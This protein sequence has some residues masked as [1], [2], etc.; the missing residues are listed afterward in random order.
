MKVHYSGSQGKIGSDDL[1]HFRKRRRDYTTILRAP[2]RPLNSSRRAREQM[3]G[4]D[5]DL[6][7]TTFKSMD[8][9]ITESIIGMRMS[10][11]MMAVL[12][13][14]ALRACVGRRVR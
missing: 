12:G 3:R 2:E 5:P 9:L 6:R 7:S 8:R 11:R 13:V 10:T 1:G 4:S 14:I